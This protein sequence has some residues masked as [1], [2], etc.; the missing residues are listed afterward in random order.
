MDTLTIQVENPSI[1]ASL[2]KILKAMNGVE[3]LP[4]SKMK[5]CGLEEALEDIRCGRVTEY[6]SSE[7]MFNKLGI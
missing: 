3:I 1:L 7:D 5:K 2:K 4:K 6:K